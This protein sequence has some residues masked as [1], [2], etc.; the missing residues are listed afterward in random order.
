MFEELQFLRQEVATLRRT[1]LAFEAQNQ[2]VKAMISVAQASTGRLM[3]RSMLLE[4]IK[5]TASLVEAQ[6]SSL[7]LVDEFGVVIESILARGAA[8]RE[9]K[10]SLIGQVL[11]KGLAGWVVKNRQVG[12]IQDTRLDDRWLTLPNQP[13]TVGSALCVPILQGSKLIG[14]LTFTHPEINRFS[15][16]NADLMEMTAIQMALVLDNARMDRSSPRAH[17]AP[18]PPP[19]QI[20]PKLQD[21]SNLGVF[22]IG[23]DGKFLYISTQIS[24]IFGYSIPEIL[25]MNSALSL[26]AMDSRKEFTD[27]FQPCFQGQNNQV[28]CK[29]HG[30]SKD[31]RLIKLE[32][33]GNRTKFYGKFMIV[34]VLGE[35]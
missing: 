31:G 17:V 10:E 13:Y 5:I 27:Q 24:E 16:E 4:T 23:M 18:S 21:I 1:R 22:M 28:S 15:Q 20:S 19:E 33:S 25:E 14:I 26:V 29:F 34:G 35:V 9:V 30:K 12:I 11:D 7:F 3:L 8:I 6:D 2:L 32:L